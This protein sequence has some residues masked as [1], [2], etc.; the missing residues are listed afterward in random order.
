MVSRHVAIARRPGWRQ[1]AVRSLSPLCGAREHCARAL[2]LAASLPEG[3]RPGS[4][5][6]QALH[7]DRTWMRP[8][9]PHSGLSARPPPFP[10]LHPLP[11]AL[12]TFSRQQQDGPG[13]SYM[14]PA[15]MPARSAQV[16]QRTSAPPVV[17]T[18][19][20]SVGRARSEGIILRPLRRGRA[21][22]QG[23][24]PRCATVATPAPS[25]RPTARPSRR[26]SIGQGCG[27]LRPGAPRC[28]GNG[29]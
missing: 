28:G 22:L 14:S 24:R 6:G 27:P 9:P 10:G 15:D 18:G 26:A 12:L 3:L 20:S 13:D 23:R 8:L 19:D 4:G 16:R 5:A 1:W 2:G 21:G 11:G 17:G 25:P 7:I 29:G